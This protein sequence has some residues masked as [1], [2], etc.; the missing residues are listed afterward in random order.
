MVST[1]YETYRLA[2]NEREFPLAYLDR[3]ALDA[4]IRTTRQ[5]AGNLPVRVASKSIRCRD[6]LRYI[7]DHEGF[8][9]VMCYTGYEAAHLTANGFEDLLVAY[10]V[11]HKNE[12]EAV[13]DAIETGTRLTLMVDDAAH[14]ER[15][16]ETAAENGVEVP[17]CI[18]IDM[19][20]EHLG[21]HFGVRRSGVQTPDAALSLAETIADAG[22]V[23]LAGVMGYEAQIAGLP[24]D[25]PSNNAGMNAAIRG[26]KRR[27]APMLRE[28]RE[29]VVSALDRAGYDL[30]FVNSGG[31]GSVEVTRRDVSVTELTIGSGFYAPHL[32]DYYREFQYE[33]AAGYAIEIVRQ[34]T[35]EIYTCR[36]GGYIA[37]GPPGIDKAPVPHLP[38]GAALLSNEGAGE[39]QT[40][41]EYD[42][43]VKLSLGD[44]LL[45]RHAKAGELCAHFEFLHVIADGE[46]V[47]R[48]PTYR[49]DGECFL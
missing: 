6:A 35:S 31:T 2:M 23:E 47:D 1:A 37:S 11:W 18:D 36:G 17:V 39:V 49:G 15:I 41:V 32:F 9:G 7:L 27:S 10:P 44:P 42:G 29:K 16:S 20:T 43:P 26:L 13:C 4:N 12:L 3:D 21:V 34:P 40:P 19:S 30:G 28:R 46:L 33:P 14:V 22:C 8:R 48:Y 38:K 5:R 45:F 25:D 24:D